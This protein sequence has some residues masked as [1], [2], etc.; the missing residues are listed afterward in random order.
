[1]PC[2]PSA[3]AVFHAQLILLMFSA[4]GC[5][6]SSFVRCIVG[7]RTH[8][9]APVLLDPL[10]TSPSARLTIMG[11]RAFSHSALCL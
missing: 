2:N 8:Q 4:V 7:E 5:F 6:S 3:T 10:I 1:M 11:S 9:H